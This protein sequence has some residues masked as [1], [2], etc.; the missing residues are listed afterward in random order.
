MPSGDAGQT[1]RDLPDG[2]ARCGAG[3]GD[4]LETAKVTV[5]LGQQTQ[6][7][8]VVTGT[9]DRQLIRRSAAI[10]T[11]QASFGRSSEIGPCSTPAHVRPAQLGRRPLPHRRRQLLGQ[12][13]SQ[14]LGRFDRPAR[15]SNRAAQPTVL[16]SAMVSP[17]SNLSEVGLAG[18]DHDGGVGTLVRVDPDCHLHLMPPGSSPITPRVTVPAEPRHWGGRVDLPI[19]LPLDWPIIGTI[20]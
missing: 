10:A 8:G 1:R 18:V 16:R 5:S 14:T 4:V 7:A 19:A 12:Q 3:T 13:I 2:C 20:A 11:E 6:H 15:W 17:T 9:H